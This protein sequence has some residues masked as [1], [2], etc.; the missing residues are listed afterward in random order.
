MIFSSIFFS[1]RLPAC[2]FDPL[3]SRAMEA[4]KYGSPHCQPDLLCLGRT[5]IRIPDA[6]QHPL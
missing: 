4:E 6:F 2:D 3:L 5:S 1:F